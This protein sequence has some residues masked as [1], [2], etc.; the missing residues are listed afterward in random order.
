MNF[1]RDSLW[2]EDIGTFFIA[3]IGGVVQGISWAARGMRFSK[4]EKQNPKLPR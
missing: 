3:R 1:L 2:E 4:R